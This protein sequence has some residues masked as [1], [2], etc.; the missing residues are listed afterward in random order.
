MKLTSRNSCG[1]TSTPASAPS[2]AASPQPIISVR[3]TLMPTSRLEAGLA[4]AARIASPSLVRLKSR[5]SSPLTASRIATIPS[6]S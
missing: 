2:S 3:P 6:D 4:A 5:N 1:A